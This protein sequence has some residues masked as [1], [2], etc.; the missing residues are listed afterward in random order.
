[1]VHL[2]V[3]PSHVQGIT[4]S[5]PDT[6]VTPAVDVGTFNVRTN[7]A[8]HLFDAATPTMTPKDDAPYQYNKYE[9]SDTSGK[10]RTCFACQSTTHLY[11]DCQDPRKAIMAKERMN[12][13]HKRV[14]AAGKSRDLNGYTTKTRQTLDDATQL[15]PL[16]ARGYIAS[17]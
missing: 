14:R 7:P 2:N 5:I 3:M 6:V 17:R 10:P 15:C 11:A 8:A 16:W 9:K 1:L 12:L 4:F 13:L